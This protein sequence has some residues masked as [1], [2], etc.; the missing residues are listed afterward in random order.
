MNAVAGQV[1]SYESFGTLDGPGLR[2]VVFLQGCPFRCR[3]CHNPD[4]WNPGAGRLVGADEVVARIARCRAYLRNG[5]ATISGGEPLMQPAFALDLLRRLREER[6]HSALDTS[7]L[8]PLDVATPAI[9]AADMLLLDVKTLDD[10]DCRAL[11]G[12]TSAH[13]LAT[14]DYCD[15]IRKRVWIRHVVVPGLTLVPAKL[16]ALAAELKRH[17]CIERVDLLPFNKLGEFKWR[18]LGLAYT[19]ADTPV[20]TPAQMDEARATF[21]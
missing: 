1:H 17:A 20:P 18:E 14:L 8:V 4:T 16:Q 9:D 12:A 15:R 5:G 3:Y 6:I 7:G 2:F 13:V 11:T 10:D 19:L 21:T